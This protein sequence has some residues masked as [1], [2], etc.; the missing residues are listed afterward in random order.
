MPPFYVI[1]FI[2]SA[3]L[4]SHS[5][6]RVIV[7]VLFVAMLRRRDYQKFSK[8]QISLFYLFLGYFFFH[9]LSVIN[10][11][12]YDAFLLRYKDVVFPGL[13]LLASFSFLKSK[14]DFIKVMIW[15]LLVNFAY[16][17]VA[18]TWPSLYSLMGNS[19]LYEG[20]REF[21]SLNLARGRIF[22]ETY[23]EIVL[24][25]LFVSGFYT[26]VKNKL[27]RVIFP[28][29][30]IFPTLLSN[31][32]SR[33]LM[34][35][36]GVGLALITWFKSWKVVI[37]I[38]LG[39]IVMMFSS[40]AISL[41]LWGFSIL[42][43]VLLKSNYDDIQSLTSRWEGISQSFELGLRHPVAGIGLGNY[44]DFLPTYVRD[45]VF[46][47]SNYYGGVWISSLNPHNI[48]AQIVAET[49][50]L[51]LIYYLGMLGIFLRSDWMIYRERKIKEDFKIACIIAFWT[52][53]S[54]SLFNPTTTLT[55]NTLFWI[56]R[57]VIIHESTS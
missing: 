22:I 55:Y 21:V 4:T 42:D 29:L 24:P 25:F 38:G 35:V 1:P 8:T 16:Q 19:L 45:S 26:L 31:F 34:L 43:R 27:F 14:L 20:H 6:S 7:V 9:S 37:G 13:F 44:F 41:R 2:K 11:V 5:L 17:A 40:D 12:N 30:I 10:A 33:L 28:V 54:Y 52:L 46:S 48:F 23:D 47:I 36:V 51:G 15:S 39:G 57:G 50:L 53:F 49:G 18:Y 3:L 56:L 32:R